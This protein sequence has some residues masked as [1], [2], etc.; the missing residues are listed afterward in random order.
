MTQL[1]K[2]IQLHKELVDAVRKRDFNR[3]IRIQNKMKALREETETYSVSEYIRGLDEDIR[4]KVYT[5]MLLVH[6][7]CDLLSGFAV[8]LDGTLKTLNE[9]MLYTMA[10]KVSAELKKSSNKL[11]EMI[12]RT[13]DDEFVE[14]FEDVCD[15]LSEM[16]MK[17]VEERC[18]KM[19]D[20]LMG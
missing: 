20:I 19:I 12:Y 3:Q 6:V 10:T 14:S 9:D 2:E 4:R 15:E 7:T 11:V 8:D 1:E 16:V 5:Q 17:K 13:R 18:G